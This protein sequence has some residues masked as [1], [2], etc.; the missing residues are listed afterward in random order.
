MGMIHELNDSVSG[1]FTTEDIPI[2]PNVMQAIDILDI[3]QVHLSCY[4]IV[5][6]F[7]ALKGERL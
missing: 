2:S 6:I 7:L 4:F 3:L 5:V 1:V